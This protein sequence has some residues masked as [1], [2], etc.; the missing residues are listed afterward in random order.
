MAAFGLR[1]LD[2]PGA[3]KR[4][5]E[6]YCGLLLNSARIEQRRGY[7]LLRAI[8][9]AFAHVTSGEL[10]PEYFEALADS[11]EDAKALYD[12][13]RSRVQWARHSP[14]R[15]PEVDGG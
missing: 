8:A 12:L 2:W 14:L 5:H 15:T 9:D 4:N 1:V 13:Y 3:P 6:L 10:A 7:G 11:P